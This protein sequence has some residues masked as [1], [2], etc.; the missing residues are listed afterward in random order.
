MH[1][2]EG[3]WVSHGVSTKDTIYRMI[4]KNSLHLSTKAINRSRMRELLHCKVQ[5]RIQDLRKGG[6]MIRTQTFW[7][8]P[9]N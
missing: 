5:W 7:P 2:I 9:Q 1:L 6:T 8:H 4:M 3:K